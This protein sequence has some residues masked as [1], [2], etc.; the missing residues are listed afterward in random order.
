MFG[1]I[2]M[3]L[4]SGWVEQLMQS[5]DRSYMPETTALTA[6]QLYR[7]LAATF[8][9]PLPELDSSDLSSQSVLVQAG[10]LPSGADLEVRIA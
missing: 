6:T 4:F 8:Q 7:K 1:T 5:L 9:Q 2:G 3:T 10:F